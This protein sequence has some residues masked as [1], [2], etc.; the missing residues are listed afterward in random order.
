[1]SKNKLRNEIIVSLILGIVIYM[2]L[3]LV[4]K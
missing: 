3:S 2:I 4:F 1:M